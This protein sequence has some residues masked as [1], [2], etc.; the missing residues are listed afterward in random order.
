MRLDQLGTVTDT[1]EELRSFA[2]YNGQDVVVF[3]VFRAKGASEVSRRRRSRNAA[4]DE[5]R[6]ENPGVSIDLVDDTVYY[7]YGNYEAAINTLIE[8]ALLAV[9]RGVRCSCGTGARR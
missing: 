3:A 5:I 6:A 4:L 7:T 2:R 8:G 1:Y 9:H